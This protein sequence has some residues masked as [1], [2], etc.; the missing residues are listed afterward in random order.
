MF[1]WT[2]CLAVEN[3]YARDLA[4]LNRRAIT[5]IPCARMTGTSLPKCLR[6]R[7]GG[8]AGRPSARQGHRRSIKSL[9]WCSASRS[10]SCGVQ[11]DI[12]RAGQQRRRARALKAAID[13]LREGDVLA[14]TKRVLGSNLDP[15]TG[16]MMLQVLGAVAEHEQL[17]RWRGIA[18]G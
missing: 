1:D 17:R 18:K 8:V 11:K 9:V 2:G 5:L 4:A 15:A 6:S 16:R 7:D 12:R 10:K 14:R 13:Y 3:I